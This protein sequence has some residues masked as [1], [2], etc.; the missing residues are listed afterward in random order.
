MTRCPQLTEIGKWPEFRAFFARLGV[1]LSQ[2]IKRIDL[3]MDVDMPTELRVEL[4][5]IDMGEQ[6]PEAKP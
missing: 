4:R 2:I 6:K 3:E 5:A 1:D